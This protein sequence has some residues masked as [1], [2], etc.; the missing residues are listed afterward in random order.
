MPLFAIEFARV[1][2]MIARIKQK[3]ERDFKHFCDFVVV[4]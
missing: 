2:L 1:A 4:R 3:S